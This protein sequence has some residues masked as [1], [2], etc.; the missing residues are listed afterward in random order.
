MEATIA[1]GA[2]VLLL[3]L[4]EAALA[5]IDLLSF[6]TT[7][8][9]KG[10][11]NVP[12]GLHFV[13]TSANNSLSIRH[14]AWFRVHDQPDDQLELFV[15][16]WDRNR[17][18]LVA[19]SDESEVLRWHA[20]VGSIWREGLTPYRQ[21][22]V[23]DGTEAEEKTDW[24]S[25][26]DEI[27]DEMLSRITNSEIDHWTLTTASSAT[28]D[29]DDIPG[30]PTDSNE[31]QRDKELRFLPV[32]LKITWPT[33]A[34]GRERTEA[35][36]DHSWA[37][38][39]LIE[40]YCGNDQN[41]I[42]GELQFCFLTLLTLNNYSCLEQWKRLLRL[43]LTSKE[44]V[45]QRPQLYTKAIRLLKLQLQHANDADGGLFDMGEAGPNILK[46]LL[47]KFK[48]SLN[49]LQGSA[50]SDVMDGLDELEAF[51]REEYGWELDDNFARRG[52]VRLEDGESVEVRLTNFDE[53]DEDGEWAPTVVELSPEQL[54]HLGESDT[55]IS[56]D[57]HSGEVREDSEDDQDLGDMDPRY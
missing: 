34:T 33:G 41:A 46:T 21:G 40:R 25:L 57:S 30:L 12:P 20:N 50:K 10:V 22:V 56:A 26:T 18:G 32:D 42:L 43:L 39:D 35:A 23:D 8:R 53:E 47:R 54:R 31:A 36:L 48:K 3:D 17:E 16:K 1:H 29:L 24:T 44:A 28:R 14:G 45:E 38:N 49:D 11:K 15:K 9:F 5:G 7:P 37:L 6:T 27:S 51:V 13:F 2:A 4:P 52:M 19:E 55:Y